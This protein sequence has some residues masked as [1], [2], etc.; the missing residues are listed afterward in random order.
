[1]TNLA[2]AIMIASGEPPLSEPCAARRGR[3]QETDNTTARFCMECGRIAP[4]GYGVHLRVGQAG[5][6]YCGEHRPASE[7]SVAVRGD[8]AGSRPR[9]LVDA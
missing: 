3:V 8:G 1:M 4:F 7:G 5:H 9:S 6:W 2:V